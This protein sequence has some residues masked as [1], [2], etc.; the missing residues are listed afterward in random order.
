V[1]CLA[2]TFVKMRRT[3]RRRQ[4]ATTSSGHYHA[5]R[6]NAADGGKDKQIHERIG[7]T[8]H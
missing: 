6:S 7:E 3:F 2:E 8:G 4:G 1:S 5:R